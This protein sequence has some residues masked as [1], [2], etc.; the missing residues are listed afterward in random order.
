[1]RFLVVRA[2]DSNILNIHGDTQ[3][4]IL[5]FQQQNVPAKLLSRAMNIQ[6]MMRMI[7]GHKFD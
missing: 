2:Q 3:S 1:M 4:S 7:V 5:S 6:K